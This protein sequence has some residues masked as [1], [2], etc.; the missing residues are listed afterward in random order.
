MSAM[1]SSGVERCYFR[2]SVNGELSDRVVLQLDHQA[3][4]ILSAKLVDLFRCGFFT[5]TSILAKRGESI[6]FQAPGK[7][8]SKNTFI[9][10]VSHLKEQR[11]TVRFLVS[12]VREKRAFCS[13]D[14]QIMLIDRPNHDKFTTVFAVIVEGIGVCDTTSYLNLRFHQVSIGETGIV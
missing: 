11:G 4:P 6:I 13:K 7:E 9:A 14:L 10:D 3:T 12:E 2:F 5:G 8:P 1:P